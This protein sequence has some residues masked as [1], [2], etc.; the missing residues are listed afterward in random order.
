MLI[1]R[2]RGR[3]SAGSLFTVIII[4]TA[5]KLVFVTLHNIHVYIFRN[6]IR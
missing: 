3:K 4:T 1:N 6:T 5:F 2:R